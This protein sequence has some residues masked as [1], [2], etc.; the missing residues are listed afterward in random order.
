MSAN[1]TSI[2]QRENGPLV[3]K[4]VE[5]LRL[6]D[7][8]RAE[9]KSVMALCRCGG[10]S[11]KPFCDGTHN[12]NGFDSA[13]ADVTARDEVFTYEGDDA[14]I[15]YNRLLCSHAAEC[16]A[17]AIAIFN[18]KQKPWIQPNVGTVDQMVEVA[19]ACPSGALRYA[20]PG[21]SPEL[22]ADDEVSITVEK[23]GPYRVKNVTIEVDYWAKGQS[24]RKYVLCRCGKS[25]N[26]PFCD[27]SH[28]D[29]QWRDG[30]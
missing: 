4:N 23:D 19:S 15:T 18:P 1:T 16:S 20:S 12:N 10:S 11:N 14:T 21:G 22:L 2:E 29:A 7:G 17:R 30:A 25:G 13:G 8:T 5:I 28:H 6:A 3:V 9:V 26:K 24:S 27:G